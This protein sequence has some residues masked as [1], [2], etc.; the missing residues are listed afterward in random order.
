MDEGSKKEAVCT[1][2]TS[3]PTSISAKEI[4]PD[5]TFPSS[6]FNDVKQAL[7]DDD[8]LKCYIQVDIPTKSLK[9]RSFVISCHTRGEF[10]ELLEGI[11]EEQRA[12]NTVDTDH[13]LGRKTSKR[14]SENCQEKTLLYS[15]APLGVYETMTASDI[16]VFKTHQRYNITTKKDDTGETKEVQPFVSDRISEEMMTLNVFKR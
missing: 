12:W 10:A 11:P 13:F 7:L 2:T 1:N 15:T 9:Q 3:E 8:T 16:K 14:C 6:R 5:G 4:V